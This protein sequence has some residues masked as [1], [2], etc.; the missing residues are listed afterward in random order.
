MKIP[1][2]IFSLI[3]GSPRIESSS[4]GEILT[5]LQKYSRAGIIITKPFGFHIWIMIKK[6]EGND[7]IGWKPGTEIGLYARTPGYRWDADLGMIKTKGYI[8]LHWD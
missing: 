2:T 3:I 1:Y 7:I 8:G 5:H 6:Q 4:R